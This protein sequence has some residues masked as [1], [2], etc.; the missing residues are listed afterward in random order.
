MYLRAVLAATVLSAA[1]LTGIAPAQ[2]ATPRSIPPCSASLTS[3]FDNGWSIE[4]P[5][6]WHVGD[7]AFGCNLKLGDRD[8]GAEFDGVSTLQ[9]NLNSCYR[10]RLVIDGIYG[11]KTRDAVRR[12]QR[13]HHI[14]SDGV[15]GPQ[16][17]S[18]MVWRMGNYKLHR[19]SEKCYSPI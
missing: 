15:Y 17:R 18:A 8:S 4:T 9:R 10:T 1:P 11:P 16:T 12:V 3:R 6:L 2:A 19:V 5:A 13:L 14:T 7:G